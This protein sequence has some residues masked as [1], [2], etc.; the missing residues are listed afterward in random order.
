MTLL[1]FRKTPQYFSSYSGGF[2]NIRQNTGKF[3]PL[4][5]Y[6]DATPRQHALTKHALEM[7]FLKY[8]IEHLE[9][10]KIPVFSINVLEVKADQIQL[11]LIDWCDKSGSELECLMP[12]VFQGFTN[13]KQ[14]DLS[15]HHLKRL[16]DNCFNGLS[17]LGCL[18]LSN[19]QLKFL[20]PNLFQGLFNLKHLALNDNQLSTLVNT[21]TGLAN[22]KYLLVGNNQLEYIDPD[23]FQP[24]KRLSILCL[25][26]N[27]L[28]SI[29]SGVFKDLDTLCNLRL[30]GNDFPP[31]HPDIFKP[32]GKFNILMEFEYIG[33]EEFI[34]SPRQH[35]LNKSKEMC[36]A[37]SRGVCQTMEDAWVH[38]D[39]YY[40]ECYYDYYMYR[41]WNN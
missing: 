8:H 38:E 27:K 35:L 4:A 36:E 30:I 5:A 13:L 22:L 26:K 16:P 21:F 14:L 19:N 1:Y 28:Q 17:N 18:D 11:S 31:L 2:M 41:F 25:E 24:L 40:E 9:V 20:R 7:G 23:A 39:C 33:G 34:F 3:L 37:L 10:Y 29:D 15:Q 6:T 32:L 12:D